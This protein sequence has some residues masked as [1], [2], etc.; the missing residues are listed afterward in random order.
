MTKLA[1]DY[2]EL[3]APQPP[4]HWLDRSW[5]YIPASSHADASDFRKRQQERLA[6]AQKQRTAA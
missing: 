1:H 3:A 6:E 2:P 5:T 4:A